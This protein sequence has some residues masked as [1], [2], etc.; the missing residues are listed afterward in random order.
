MCQSPKVGVKVMLK[1]SR[2]II[3]EM[4][5]EELGRLMQ[6]LLQLKCLDV[7]TRQW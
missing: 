4:R 3:K 7:R 5:G 6:S 1:E 2:R